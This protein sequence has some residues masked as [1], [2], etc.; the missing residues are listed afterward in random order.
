MLDHEN[1]N[2]SIVM[3]NLARS[4]ASL[5][6]ENIIIEVSFTM[7]TVKDRRLV[8]S[9]RST[10]NGALETPNCRNQNHTNQRYKR[11]EK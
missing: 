9:V 4:N 10:G 1:P 7:S 8:F 5:Q 6:M 2:S 3:N 11:V